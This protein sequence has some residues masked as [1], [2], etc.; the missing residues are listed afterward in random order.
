MIYL[1]LLIYASLKI[2]NWWRDAELQVLVWDMVDPA[3]KKPAEYH[4]KR[5]IF[6]IL[7]SLGSYLFLSWLS[8]EW[9]WS[10]L[11][12]IGIDIIGIVV[13]ELR[14]C[15]LAYG[16]WKFHKEWGWKIKLW[17]T[18]TIS[19]PKWRHW[20]LIAIINFIGILIVGK[21][22]AEAISDKKR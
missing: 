13:Y 11:F 9:F 20:I 15:Y 3:K 12:V 7:V 18:I 2:Y 8:N 5:S 17:K 10:L 1:F 19:Y 16:D 21:H 6:L 14:Y 4:L 22:L